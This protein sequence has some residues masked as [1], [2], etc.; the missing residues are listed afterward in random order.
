MANLVSPLSLFPPPYRGAGRNGI[1]RKQGT[2]LTTE[3]MLPSSA[4]A[5]PG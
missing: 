3:E 1:A 4:S 5:L 2:R